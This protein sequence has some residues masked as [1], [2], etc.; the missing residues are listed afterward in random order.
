MGKLSSAPKE[1]LPQPRNE[2]GH[3]S[4]EPGRCSESGGG[5]G[6]GAGPW[7]PQQGTASASLGSRC[8][9]NTL[10]PP[11]PG[12]RELGPTQETRGTVA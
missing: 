2:A 6:G 4:V 5:G 1:P 11:S 3:L 12:H 8:L 10:E 7:S 9:P